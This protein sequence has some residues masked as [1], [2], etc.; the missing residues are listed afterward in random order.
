MPT[1]AVLAA[2]GHCAPGPAVASHPQGRWPRAPPRPSCLP[3]ERAPRRAPRACCR[4]RSW[5]LSA[6]GRSSRPRRCSCTTRGHAVRPGAGA[7]DPQ[8]DTGPR[9]VG[10]PAA[11]APARRAAGARPTTAHASPASAPGRA[12]RAPSIA[13]SMRSA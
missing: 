13:C 11:T 2:P 7:L 8:S 10:S 1:A 12:P 5:R 6:F 9:R 3:L 4:R